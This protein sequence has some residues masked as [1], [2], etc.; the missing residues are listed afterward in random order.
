M[1]QRD[2][3]RVWCWTS[4]L[5]HFFCDLHN[6]VED[7]RAPTSPLLIIAFILSCTGAYAGS[8]LANYVFAVRAWHVL[9]GLT[10]SMDDTQVKAALTGAA[11]LA[12][13]TSKCPKRVPITVGLMECIFGRLNLTDPL[14]A[15]VAGCFSMILYSVAC[16]GELT[17]TTLMPLILCSLSSHPIY[18]TEQIATTWK[19]QSFVSLEPSVLQK[20]RMCSGHIMTESQIPRLLLI[21][22]S[23]PTILWQIDYFL[24]TDMPKDYVH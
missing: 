20:V 17:L 12:P 19:S 2:Q 18:P 11:I 24:H 21:T 10:W 22:T 16:T 15:A 13:P 8:T 7:D 5:P 23:K 9:H 14:D 3:G 4:S 1:G 6:I